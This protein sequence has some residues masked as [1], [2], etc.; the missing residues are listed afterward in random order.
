MVS[1]KMQVSIVRSYFGDTPAN[2]VKAILNNQI[3]AKGDELKLNLDSGIRVKREAI[4]TPE[5]V[6][7]QLTI[8]KGFACIVLAEGEDPEYVSA[9]DVGV[10]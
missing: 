10:D 1:N 2:I 3:C 6:H 8:Q 5:G 7:W 4:N 9:T